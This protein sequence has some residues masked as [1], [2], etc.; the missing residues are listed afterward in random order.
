M[1]WLTMIPWRLVGWLALAA[2]IA[3]GGSKAGSAWVQSS[4][5][6]ERAER[7]TQALANAT[8]ELKLK[9]RQYEANQS[10]LDLAAASARKARAA[11]DLSRDAAGRLFDDLSAAQRAA[12]DADT[13]CP[14]DAETAALRFV[15]GACVGRYR[16]VAAEAG[17]LAGELAGLQAWTAGICA[18][19][20]TAEG[21][22][23][24][25]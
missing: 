8:K 21:A 9:D 20:V 1:P 16:D 25:R 18:P 22:R 23:G 12:D 13:S 3:A 11:A 19:A 4:W 5:D 10:A 15:V 24:D 6:A 7:T 2:G 17:G 14:A